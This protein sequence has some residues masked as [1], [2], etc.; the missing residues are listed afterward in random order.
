MLSAL[1][2]VILK[3]SALEKYIIIIIIIYSLHF[4]WVAIVWSFSDCV[5]PSKRTKAENSEEAK[6]NKSKK[7]LTFFLSDVGRVVST[8]SQTASGSNTPTEQHLE[9]FVC[10]YCV[11]RNRLLCDLISIHVQV[12]HLAFAQTCC[13]QNRVSVWVCSVG[14]GGGGKVKSAWGGIRR[15]RSNPREFFFFSLSFF[16]FLLL[17]GER[18]FLDSN[19]QSTAQGHLRANPKSSLLLYHFKTRHWITF[20]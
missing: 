15:W 12:D 16:F 11:A 14:T 9:A 10:L 5:G 4:I 1:S 3:Y 2:P 19:G 13:P 8:H 17:N 7:Q 20:V 6:K 18:Q